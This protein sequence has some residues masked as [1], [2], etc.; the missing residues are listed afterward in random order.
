MAYYVGIKVR[1]AKAAESRGSGV[2]WGGANRVGG[3]INKY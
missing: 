3:V 1:S 2:S